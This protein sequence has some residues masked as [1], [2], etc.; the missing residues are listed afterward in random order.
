MSPNDREEGDLPVD[1][2]DDSVDGPDLDEVGTKSDR[3]LDSPQDKGP[4]TALDSNVDK[5]ALHGL[6]I[7]YFLDEVSDLYG[8]P[9]R[10]DPSP[11]DFDWH[12]YNV[13]SP[14]YFQVGIKGDKVVALLSLTGRSGPLLD[15]ADK[16]SAR[17]LF[18]RPLDALNLGGRNYLERDDDERKER[19]IF[20]YGSNY[21]Y[22][23]YDLIDNA[24]S[25]VQLIDKLSRHSLLAHYSKGSVELGL[26]FERQE[27]DLSNAM[28]ASRGLPTYTWI[29]MAALSARGHSEDMARSNFFEHDNLKG[30]SPLDR[31]EAVGIILG[32]MAENIIAGYEDPLSMH[33]G[34]MNSPGH[35]ANLLIPN[36]EFLGLGVAFGGQHKIYATQNFF[37][38]PY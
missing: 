8:N 35:R 7:G 10:I 1:S 6:E 13:G 20:A 34:W 33:T 16:D 12:I 31:M 30:E 29:N 21:V 36:L 15:L 14:D 3:E 5:L 38:L 17:Q 26:A 18:G 28:R 9:E 2:L 32:P 22:V 27:F 11:Y 37:S 24:I 25:G 19:D 23:Y 4:L